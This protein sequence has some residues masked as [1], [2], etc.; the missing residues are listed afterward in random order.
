MTRQLA[1]LYENYSAI[2]MNSYVIV[3]CVLI[4]HLRGVRNIAISVSVY[5]S[6]CS[7]TT[8]PTLANFVSICTCYLWQWLD[9]PLTAMQYVMYFPN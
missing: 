3:H 5:L 9:P 4:Y 1:T 2:V 7:E 6:V 8:C